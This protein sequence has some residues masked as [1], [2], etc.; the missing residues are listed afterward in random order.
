LGIGAGYQSPQWR[1]LGSWTRDFVKVTL[2][3]KYIYLKQLLSA[4]FV[5]ARE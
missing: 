1:G 5:G 2:S 4:S 3:N